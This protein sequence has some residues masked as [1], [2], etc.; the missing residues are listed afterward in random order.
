MTNIFPVDF[1]EKL[2]MAQD[3]YILFSDSEDGNKIKKAQYKNLKWEKG[4]KWDTGATWPQGETWPQWPQGL[5]WIQ[6]P[7][8]EKWETGE[9]GE[10]GARI[11]SGAF[12]GN[13]LV[14]WETDWHIVTIKNAKTILTWPKWDQWEKW[15]QGEQGIQWNKWPQWEQGETWN[16]IAS[17]TSSKSWKITTVTI[18]ETD[19]DT[20]SFE[21][22]DGAD[23]E[24]WDIQWTLSDQ[25][26]LQTALNGKVN[27]GANTEDDGIQSYTAYY[28]PEHT[29]HSIRDDTDSWDDLEIYAG[30]ITH[31]TVS[32]WIGTS[33]NYTF[34]VGSNGDIV[35]MKDLSWSVKYEDFETSTVVWATLTI[36]YFTTQITPSANFT[37]VAGT[38]KEGMQYIVRVNS[39]A[40]A[41]TM[42]LWTGVTNPFGEDLTLTASK[43]TTVVLLATSSST[44]EIFSIR[45]AE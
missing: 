37:L 1:E 34:G 45:T 13:D 8:W 9:T 22:S 31:T 14:F 28:M 25:T 6:W 40:T 12:S 5:Q 39:W 32:N 19:W 24:R 3:D 43:T 23:S 21:I 44:L 35:R 42:S 11:D 18:T 16:W 41:Y 36:S 33:E 20:E 27:L 7:Q 4:D 2:T 29:I 17:I 15:E 26:D 30:G 38:V 10:T